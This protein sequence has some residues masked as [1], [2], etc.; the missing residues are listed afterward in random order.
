M[1]TRIRGLVLRSIATTRNPLTALFERKLGRPLTHVLR[2]YL[3]GAPVYCEDQIEIC[4]DG[5]WIGGWYEWSG[6]P[7]EKPLLVFDLD[8]VIELDGSELL[9]RPNRS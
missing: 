1:P 4:I 9:R 8:D 2:H 7:S 3:D 5:I 6:Q